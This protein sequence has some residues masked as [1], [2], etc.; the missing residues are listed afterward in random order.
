MEPMFGI[1][2]GFEKVTCSQSCQRYCLTR[3]TYNAIK[4]KE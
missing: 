3:G 2:N 4:Y 1:Q